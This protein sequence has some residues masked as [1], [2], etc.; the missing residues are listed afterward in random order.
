MLKNSSEI[1]Q[2]SK[3]NLENTL[4]KNIATIIYFTQEIVTSTYNPKPLSPGFK[5]KSVDLY[6]TIK[7]CITELKHGETI[8]QS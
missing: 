2:G 6:P 5:Q 3:P 8:P 4:W 1:V 7:K